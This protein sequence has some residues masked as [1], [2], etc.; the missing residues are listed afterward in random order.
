M[1]SPAR[2]AFVT[3]VAVALAGASTA[4]AG[5]RKK[6]KRAKKAKVTQPR[7]AKRTNMPAGW[8]WPPSKAMTE[9]GAACTD[10]LDAL[11][12]AWKPARKARKVSTPITL[13]AMEIG[14]VKLVSVYR[15]GP[16]VMD[17][18]LALGLAKHLP[19]LHA[20]GVR[21]L[22]FSR[23]HEYSKVR[24]NGQQLKSLSRHALGLAIDIRSF[25]DADGRKAIVLDDY[26]LGDALLLEVEKALGDSG[27]F[28]TILT[29]RNDPQSHDDHYHLEVRVDYTA[30]P[31][32]TPRKPAT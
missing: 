27:G 16:H 14:G 25:V 19:A 6:K 9:L 20:V 32:A 17:C 8:T 15:R 29:P 13:S 22:H 31:A 11:G 1:R 4:E 30:K 12:V 10:E 3:F 28:R 24:V 18:A 23:I 7:K 2:V 26:P 5:T 21:E